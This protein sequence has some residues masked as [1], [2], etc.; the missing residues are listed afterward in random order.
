MAESS[1]PVEKLCARCDT[2]QSIDS[3]HANKS[4]KDG[5]YRWCKSC[6][7]EYDKANYHKYTD[8]RNEYGKKWVAANRDKVR[9]T[10]DRWVAENAERNRQHKRE[11]YLKN[12]DA[13][14]EERSEYKK[15]YQQENK[16]KINNQTQRR[17]ARKK[18]NGVFAIS[19]KELKKLYSSPCL[20]CGS[21]DKITVDHVIPIDKGGAH[22][23]G[24]LVPA[25]L[26]CNSSKGTKFITEWHKQKQIL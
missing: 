18:Q 3:F 19:S 15:Q 11:W 13:I 9:E 25:C 12:R 21:T 5:R 2:I 4:S 14:K 17:R 20:Y 6:R 10:H 22:S 1:T 26:S 16:E 23:I 7:K 24:N 8:R